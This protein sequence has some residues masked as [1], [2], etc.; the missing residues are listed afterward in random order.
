MMRYDP[1]RVIL[2]TIQIWW[3]GWLSLLLFGLVWAL[4]WVTLLLG[5]PATFGFFFAARFWMTEQETRWDVFLQ[6]GKK[7][8]LTSWA[9]FLANLAAAFLVYSSA[10]FYGNLPGSAAAVIRIITLASGAVWA[11]IQ[12]F[13]L[14]YFVLMEK[15]SLLQAWK[16]GLFTILASPLFSLIIFAA[17]T[18]LICF[19]LIL[20]PFFFAGPG[21]IVMLASKAIEDRVEKFG[22]RER[23][24]QHQSG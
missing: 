5:P 19:H 18:A 23:E 1:F 13:A 7:Y 3:E 6:T 9:W 4:C 2:K 14:P 21:L 22:I 12:F 20:M 24:A 8:L 10:V 15:K 11:A 16:N 17:L